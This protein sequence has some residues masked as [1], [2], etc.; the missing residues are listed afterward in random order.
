MHDNLTN[1]KP[2]LSLKNIQ[3]V[4]GWGTAVHAFAH[5]LY[6]TT[7][8]Q[9]QDAFE[10]A[11]KLNANIAMRGGAQSYGDAAIINNGIVLDLSKMNKVISWD[12]QTGIADLEPGVT[13]ENLW[14]TIIGDGYWPPVV[15]G[16]MFTTMGGCASM[17]IHGKNNF[18]AGTF[19]EHIDEFDIVLPDGTLKT[20]T[21]SLDDDLYLSAIGGFGMIGA[22][23]RIRMKMKKVFSG[24]LRVEAFNTPN[25]QA[26][27]ES[28][29][30][31][32]KT[33]DYMVGWVDT[34]CGGNG[35][36]RN[37]VH[38]AKYLKENED[39]DP[40]YLMNIHAQGL[41]PNIMGIFPKRM[42][43]FLLAPFCNKYG[44][45][46][47]NA[48]K[49]YSSLM[50]PQHIIYLQTH[51]AFNF[52]LDYVPDWKLAYGKGGLIQFQTFIPKEN[53]AKTHTEILKRA[54]QAGMPPFL[55]VFKKHKP[56]P[57]LMTHSVDGFSMALDFKVTKR[58]RE[59]LWR[60][61]HDLAE[62]ALDNGGK[63]YFAKDATMRQ[64]TPERYIPKE[65]L[66]RF[67]KVKHLYDPDNR[68]QTELSRRVFGTF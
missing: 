23:V 10:L 34:I 37:V 63:F 68:L 20:V 8:E 36:G 15:S 21:K 52:L 35:R 6:P 7:V 4:E 14:H 46:L 66:E 30:D 32:Y 11:N 31:M 26:M 3:R 49:Y 16:T 67:K 1:T 51:G 18:K 5:V 28:F 27:I 61:T 29:E 2:E 56:D 59:R 54:Q 19:G 62:L 9:V 42:V 53:A 41:P 40:R 50:T 22:I 44:M 65:D 38:R 55:G 39:P 47:I 60:L 58:N 57:F 17:N 43:H 33:S 13:I 64:G 12:P 45:R 48:A 25:I 24:Q